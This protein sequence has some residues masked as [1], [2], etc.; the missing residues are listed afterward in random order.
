MKDGVLSIMFPKSVPEERPTEAMMTC[1]NPFLNTSL[2]FVCHV[3]PRF[4]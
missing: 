4:G 2:V 1:G 3:Q